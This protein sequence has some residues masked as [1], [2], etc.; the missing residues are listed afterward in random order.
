MFT[1][2]ATD[3]A[4]QSNTA[5]LRINVDGTSG[6]F[7]ISAVADSLT[8][9]EDTTGTIANVLTNDPNATSVSGYRWGNQSTSTPGTTLTL[10][11]IGTLSI[12]SGGALTFT[13]ANDY[14]GPVPDV[15]YTASGSGSETV[16]AKVSI[17]ITAVND[18]PSGSNDAITIEKNTAAVLNVGDFGVFSDVDGDAF[19]G[20]KVTTLESAGTL[21]YYNG[22]AWVD[23]TINQVISAADISAGKLKFTPAT[24]AV[25]NNYATV[26]FQVFDGTTYSSS[27]YTLTVNVIDSVAA[28]TA[29]PP[30]NTT[31]AAQTIASYQTIAFTSG[32]SVADADNNISSTTLSVAKGSLTATGGGVSGSGT[33]TSPLVLTGTRDEINTMLATLIYTPGANTSGSDTLRMHTVDASGNSD[34]DFI[35]ITVTADNRALTITGT[36]V[37]EAS[38]YVLFSVAGTSGQHVNLSLSSGTATIGNDFLPN[39]EYFNGANW[40]AYTGSAA[41]IPSGN[42]LL[43]RTAVMQDKLNEGSE[44]LT[45]TA[46]N[47]A[48]SAATGTNTSYIVDD[49]SGDIYLASN[50]TS[51]PDTSGT[52]FPSALDDDRPITV[53]NI[54][55]NEASQWAMFTVSGYAGQSVSLALHDVTAANGNGTPAD[56]SEDFGDGLEYWTGS[57]WATYTGSVT[58]NSSTLL[59]RTAIHQDTLFEG[60]ESFTLGVTK[61]SSGATVYGLGNIY[62]DGTG[63][64]FAFDDSNDGSATITSGPGVG[65]DD[66]RALSIAD[67]SINEVSDYAVFTVSGNSGQTAT[68]ALVDESSAGTVVGKANI[69]ETQTLEVW[70]GLAWVDYDANN[71]PTFDGNGKIFIRVDIR[72]EQDTPYEGSETFKLSAT[73]TGGAAVTGIATIKDDGTGTVFSGNITGGAP[74]TTTPTLDNDRPTLTY[75]ATGFVEAASNDGTSAT[76]ITIVLSN[77][78]FTGTNGA[79]LGNVT[80]VP[81]GMNAVLI[82]SSA[83]TA[84]LTL[85]GSAA[86]HANLNDINN[87]TVTF[88]NS[89][90]SSNN[91][92]SVINATKSNLIVDFLD[93]AADTQAPTIA[94]TADKTSLKAGETATLTFTLSE[95]ASDFAQADVAVA[96]GTLS[97]WTAVSATVYTA[98][99]TPSASSGSVSVASSKFSDAA[100]NQNA[101]GADTDNSLTLTLEA[102]RTPAVISEQKPIDQP[103]PVALPQ[104]EASQQEAARVLTPNSFSAALAPEGIVLPQ[105]PY[106]P[107]LTQGEGFKVTVIRADIPTLMVNNDVPEQF[108][109]NLGGVQQFVIPTDTFAHTN[110]DASITL[111][112]KLQDGG[113][114]PSWVRFDPESG[115]FL[116]DAPTDFNGTL[117]LN[118][119]AR[120]NEGREVQVPVVFHI[121]EKVNGRLSLEEKLALQKGGLREKDLFK[122]LTDSGGFAQVETINESSLALVNVDPNPGNGAMPIPGEDQIIAEA[123]SE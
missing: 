117:K 85:T 3:G 114:L 41:V 115:K 14:T 116:I 96:G 20:I 59:V 60:Q 1:Y 54:A 69:D 26:G 31:P 45:L 81:A 62:D 66:D 104:T 119:M 111:S 48:G 56:G 89:D 13:P 58:L 52:G 82:R 30:V 107:T 43:V 68:L 94:I 19:S 24:N 83:T 118:V 7:T 21:S 113:D 70:D 100:G 87:L 16:S 74:A 98:T 17:S 86:A 42:T 79:T 77:D 37:N 5:T 105:N 46:T 55:V 72:A 34:T 121:G 61:V 36:T 50:T 51:T 25:A 110:P 35:D 90:F 123:S 23:V 8:V 93:P 65:F 63:D 76:T 27:A 9:A 91:A 6:A 22:A 71:L 112:A 102:T 33:A 10:S 4:A 11:G 122:L 12:T 64:I 101:D 106:Q 44:T 99:F 49:G 103:L 57:V 97:N 38:P 15:T 92:G 40:V 78:T 29:N 80:N 2:Q 39:L 95:G 88:A 75:S 32:L 73:L 53:N 28:S 109:E 18:A 120:D 47:M 67:L 108:L 84:T